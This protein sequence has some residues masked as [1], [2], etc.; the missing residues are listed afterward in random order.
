MSQKLL[1]NGFM[2]YNGYLSDF[3]EDFIKNYDENSDERYFL[4]VD[5]EYPK[6]YGVLIESYHFLPKR[7][8]F[9]KVE[10][11]L[12]SIDDKEK[13]FIHI[14]ALKQALDNRMKLKKI[15]RATK[16]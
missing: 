6:N 14:R 4:E 1:V 10:Q 13:Y 5:I 8:K 12:C 16:F 7:K 9:G 2:C 3:N 15:H 11:L